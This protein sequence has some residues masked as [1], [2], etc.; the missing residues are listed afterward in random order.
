MRTS[1]PRWMSL[2]RMRKRGWR[3]QR[4][5]NRICGE[6]LP[7]EGWEFVN[8][9]GDFFNPRHLREW[10]DARERGETVRFDSPEYESARKEARAIL[11]EFPIVGGV[12]EAIR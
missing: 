5:I 12:N 3:V 8:Q 10:M 2:G 6:P 11:R 7:M 4:P 9:G 1:G